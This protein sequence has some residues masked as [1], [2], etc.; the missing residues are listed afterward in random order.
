MTKEIRLL[1]S[2]MFS[3]GAILSLLLVMLAPDTPT[4]PLGFVFEIVNIV[5]LWNTLDLNKL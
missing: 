2:A 5:F 1:L 4:K 3:V